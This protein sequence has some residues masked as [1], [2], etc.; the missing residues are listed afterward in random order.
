[1]QQ[2]RPRPV[3]P[4][5]DPRGRAAPRGP[6]IARGRLYDVVAAGT[7]VGVGWVFA[8]YGLALRGRE[9]LVAERLSDAGLAPLSLLTPIVPALLVAFSVSFAV[10]LLTWLTG[11]LL[12]LSAVVGTL[13]AGT[14]HLSPFDSWG[15]TALVTAVCA[16][17]AVAGGRWS[18]DY[19]VLGTGV[20]SSRRVGGRAASATRGKAPAISHRRPEHAPPL[21]YPVGQ[22]AL[23]RPYR[24]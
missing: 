11:P 10:G 24:L 23:R 13:G 20:P 12:A 14:E 6:R 17:M 18:W 9:G 8:E 15:A 1:M 16:L 22:A 2:G 5:R 19:L 4:P 7:R 21:L 3:P